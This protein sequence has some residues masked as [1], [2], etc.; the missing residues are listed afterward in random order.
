L[1]SLDKS[2]A[3]TVF[4]IIHPGLEKE[5]RISGGKTGRFYRRDAEAR[6]RGLAQRRKGEVKCL[7]REL[8]GFAGLLDKPA[9]A[10]IMTI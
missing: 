1:S 4:Q 9:V 8:S 3:G 10:H 7:Y 5:E 6:R 2:V